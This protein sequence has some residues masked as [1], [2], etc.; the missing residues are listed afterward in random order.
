LQTHK[1]ARTVYLGPGGFA[2]S[3]ESASGPA[4]AAPEAKTVEPLVAIGRTQ[5]SRLAFIVICQGSASHAAVWLA[6]GDGSHRAGAEDNRG[7]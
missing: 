1:T 4:V 2:L 7:R 3:A 6:V 5:V